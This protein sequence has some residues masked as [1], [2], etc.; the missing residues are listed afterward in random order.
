MATRPADEKR[1]AEILARDALVRQALS[2]SAEL[3]L[4]DWWIVSGAIYNAVWNALTGRASGYGVKDI[5]LFYYDARDTSYA[6][7]DA[8]IRSAAA[9]FRASPVPVEIRNQARAH[10][11]VPEK[12]GVDYPALPNAAAAL[13]YFAATTHAVGVRLAPDGRYEIVAPFGLDDLFALRLRPN[14]VLANRATYEAKAARVAEL[15]PDVR[16]EGW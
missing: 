3:A 1:L 4:P 9:A 10:L 2:V 14:R 7:E 11:W 15:W 16:I 8:V 12:F 13:S 5:D 6:A